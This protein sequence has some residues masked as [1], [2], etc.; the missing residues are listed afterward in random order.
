MNALIAL[1]ADGVLVDYVRGYALAWEQVFGR[2]PAL[3]DPRGYGPMDRWDV[4][5]LEGTAHAQFR[6]HFDVAFWRSLPALPGAVQAC[7][8][9][10]DA[11]FE[12]LCVT[13]MDGAFESARLENL[14]ALGFPIER[15]VAVPH[16]EG[17]RSPKAAALEALGAQALVDDYLPYL[18][19]L[20]VHVH[21]ALVVRGGPGCPNVG[22]E[23]SLAKSQHEDLTEFADYWL[24]G[25]AP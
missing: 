23:L 1:D 10:H 11:G 20:P 6:R 19:G 9:L 15:V 3:K 14:R 16:T 2:R 5:W 13:A 4:P 12:L 24:E 18:R 21:A 7:H 17:P 8:R 22:P 25:A